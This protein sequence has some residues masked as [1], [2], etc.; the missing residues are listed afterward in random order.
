MAHDLHNLLFLLGEN[1]DSSAQPSE[2]LA[3]LY[4]ANSIENYDS[5]ACR[6]MTE[7]NNELLFYASHAVPE[8]QGPFFSLKFKDAT[9]TYGE[10]GDDIFAKD[11]HGHEKHYG[12]PE[13][14]HQFRKLFEA[15]N[16]VKEP[17]SILCGPEASRSQVLCVNGIQESVPEIVKF[18]ESMVRYD[19]TKKLHWV[20]DLSEVFY[21]SYRKSILPSEANVSWARCGQKI[22]LK[23]YHHYPVGTRPEDR[24]R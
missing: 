10:S 7:G 20:K 11:H 1:I 2:V 18:P 24:E 22:N 16:C 23:N 4:R 9:V 14:D 17:R 13:D 21:D 6:V 3:E 15:V 19:N 5:V 8:K 12:S